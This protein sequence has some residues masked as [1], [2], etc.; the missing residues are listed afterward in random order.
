MYLNVS[1]KKNPKDTSYLWF[2][3]QK[4]RVSSLKNPKDTTYLLDFVLT[5]H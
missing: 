5:I 4:I 2:F 1:S 3:F